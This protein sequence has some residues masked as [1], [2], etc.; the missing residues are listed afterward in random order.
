MQL[1]LDGLN[2]AGPNDEQKWVTWAWDEIKDYVLD[3]ANSCD[4]GNVKTDM[5]DVNTIRV[6]VYE[7]E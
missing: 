3:L 7:L 5:G 4:S 6:V 2:A 1:S